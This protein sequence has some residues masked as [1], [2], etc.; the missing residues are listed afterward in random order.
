MTGIY[1]IVSVLNP[2]DFILSY[3]SIHERIGRSARLYVN[4]K[5]LN[6]FPLKLLSSSICVSCIPNHYFVFLDILLLVLGYV[7]LKITIV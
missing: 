5:K 3:I 7:N 4:I 1:F 6:A 2:T